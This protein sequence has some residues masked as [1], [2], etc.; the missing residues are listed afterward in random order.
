MKLKSLI[1]AAVLFVALCMNSQAFAASAAADKVVTNVVSDNMVYDSAAN[2]VL[3]S[4]HVKV[5]HPDYIL[6]SDKLQLFLNNSDAGNKSTSAPASG[7]NA[8]VV[9]RIIAES[10]VNIQL[11]E[12]RVATCSKATYNVENETLTMEGNP[13]LREG[14]NQ[15][16][17]DKMIFYLRE[18]RNEVQGRVAVDFISGDSTPRVEET[19]GANVL[20]GGE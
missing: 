10:N 15:V 3:F 1:L 4:G 6:K 9:Q 16:R 17:G 13:A 12:G 19:K 5:T 11:P 2:K 7:I 14:A 18:N 8:G 20:G